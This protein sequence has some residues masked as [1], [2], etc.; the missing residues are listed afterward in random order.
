MKDWSLGIE[1]EKTT[2]T[3]TY[4]SEVGADFLG[5]RWTPWA[6]PP[7][8]PLA[9]SARQGGGSSADPRNLRGPPKVYAYVVFSSSRRGEEIVGL[10]ALAVLAALGELLRE[11]I[12]P[13][14]CY[15]TPVNAHLAL[16]LNTEATAQ[17]LF[18]RSLPEKS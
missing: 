1:E 6:A 16:E 10:P 12:E 4:V 15:A 5:R 2:S 17:Q 11:A 9:R 18:Y 7:A 13:I 14:A 8:P 3:Y